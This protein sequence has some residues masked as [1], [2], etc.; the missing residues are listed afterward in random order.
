MAFIVQRLT[1]SNRLQLAKEDMI[2]P[3]SFGTNWNSL[4]IAVLIQIN[5]ATSWQT[6]TGYPFLALGVCLGNSPI[7]AGDTTVDAFGWGAGN[8]GPTWTSGL[9]TWSATYNS[10]AS[11]AGGGTAFQKIG[12]SIVASNPVT[13][14]GYTLQ[15][16]GMS[17]PGG[18]TYLNRTPIYL[19]ITRGYPATPAMNNYT[20]LCNAPYSNQ[21]VDLDPGTFYD[22]LQTSTLTGTQIQYNSTLTVTGNMLWDSV[23]FSWPRL[24]PTVEIVELAVVRWG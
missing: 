17:S 19:D 2:R 21:G 20:L 23:F 6:A 8:T 1:L 18:T 22:R 3:L 12:S 16:G 14:S 5:H 9:V 4:R 10:F 24:T 7:F 15:M 13:G 11:P